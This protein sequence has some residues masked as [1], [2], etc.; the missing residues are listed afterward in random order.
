M[1]KRPSLL[2]VDDEPAILNL[3]KC[4]L[5]LSGFDVD[6]A[7][8]GKAALVLFEGKRPDLILLDIGMPGLDGFQVLKLI[9]QHSNIPVIMVTGK[10]EVIVAR[11]ALVLGADDYVRKPFD[12]LELVARVRAKLRRSYS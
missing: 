6:V 3:L 10:D 5:E 9:R 2:A 1:K 8:D 11:D 7:A 12:T 4:T